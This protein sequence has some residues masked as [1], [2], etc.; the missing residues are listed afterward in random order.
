MGV[1]PHIVKAHKHNSIFLTSDALQFSFWS[2]NFFRRT[3]LSK[4]PVVNLAEWHKTLLANK[5]LALWTEGCAHSFVYY[6]LFYFSTIFSK[7]K[8]LYCISTFL[9]C[10]NWK[11]IAT[12]ML[13]N[14]NYPIQ[15]TKL[16]STFSWSEMKSIIEVMCLTH[17]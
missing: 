1:Q 13:Y 15:C 10:R 17:E 11:W 12:S 7:Y 6:S 9:Q 4:S 2:V 3:M 16:I 8:W 5:W 14:F